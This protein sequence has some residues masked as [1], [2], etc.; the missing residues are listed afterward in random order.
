MAN[1]DWQPTAPA[2][3]AAKRTPG[4]CTVWAWRCAACEAYAECT[5]SRPAHVE[6]GANPLPSTAEL[7]Q[8]GVAADC[9]G[10]APPA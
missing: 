1:H 10:Q 5:V 3:N 6:P 8:W 9:A 2:E 7:E 4:I